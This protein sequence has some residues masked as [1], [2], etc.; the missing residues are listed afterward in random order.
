MRDARSTGLVGGF[1]THEEAHDPMHTM[2]ATPKGYQD[3]W[4]NADEPEIPALAKLSPL[5]QQFYTALFPTGMG[6]HAADELRTAWRDP[7]LQL[8]LARLIAKHESEW[9]N[10]GKWSQLIQWL[11]ERGGPSRVNEVERRR[12][13]KLV[14]WW[15]QVA[16]KV[17]G[18]PTSPDVFHVHPIGLVGNFVKQVGKVSVMMLRKI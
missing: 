14:W 13:D 7:W 16:G 18:F 10:P 4:L 11:E 8:R 2:F 6:N 17:E 12:I 5:T 1:S 15:D 9:A 3:Y